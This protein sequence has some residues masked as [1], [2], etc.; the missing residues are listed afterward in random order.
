M[1]PSY[2]E[3]VSDDTKGLLCYTE[4]ESDIESLLA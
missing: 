1:V 3:V 2:E 4:R